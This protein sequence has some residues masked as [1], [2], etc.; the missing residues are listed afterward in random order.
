MEGFKFKLEFAIEQTMDGGIRFRIL[1]L[2]DLKAQNITTH[3]LTIQMKI[4]NLLQSDTQVKKIF[5]K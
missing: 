4:T 5:M 3:Y 2:E 1:E